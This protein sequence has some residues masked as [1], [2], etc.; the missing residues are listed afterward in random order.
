[1]DDPVGGGG[2][3]NDPVSGV[4]IEARVGYNGTSALL[5]VIYSGPGAAP[6]TIGESRREESGGA[7]T[8]GTLTDGVRRLTFTLPTIALERGQSFALGADGVEAT[9]TEPSGRRWTATGGGLLVEDAGANVYSIRPVDA[10]FA[11]DPASGAQGGF[12]ASATYGFLLEYGIDEGPGALAFSDGPATNASLADFGP[13]A[14]A[15]IATGYLPPGAVGDLT[16]FLQTGR[17]LNPDRNVRLQLRSDVAPGDS[18][19]FAPA[20]PPKVEEANPPYDSVT[21]SEPSVNP[22]SRM[23]SS[24]GGTWRVVSRSRSNV[25]IALTGVTMA[26]DARTSPN[27][28]QGTFRLDGTIRR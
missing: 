23:W 4:R 28:A 19:V 7:I 12:V 5:P 1:M 10:V 11:A 16:L 8:T 13:D 18:G 9:Y 15:Y 20:P 24:T 3:T 17:A 21:Y 25:E 27:A 2:G 6:L 14:H 22:R 26:P